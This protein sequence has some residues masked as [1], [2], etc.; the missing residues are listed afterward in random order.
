MILHE[1]ISYDVLRVIWW[2]L[3]G[4]L[5]VGFAVT[6]GFDLGVGALLRATAKTDVERRVVI[7]SIG[8][9]WEGNQVWLILGGGAIFAAWPQL[10]AVSFSGFYLAMFAVLVC[11][12]VRPLAFKFRSKRED[13]AWRNRW[14]WLLTLSGWGAALVFGVA[15]GNVLQGI[16]FHLSDDLRIHYEGTFFQLFSPFALLC[17]LVSLCMLLMHGATWLVF[18]TDGVV[19]DRAIRWGAVAAVLTVLLY[20]AAGLWLTKLQGYVLTEPMSTGGPSNPLIKSASVAGGAWLTNYA[21]APVLWIVPAVGLLMPL[22]AAW[23]MKGRRE[24][25]A[26]LCSGLGIAG[27]VLS[28]GVSMFPFIL[29]S[30]VDPSMSLMVWDASSSHLT[31]F[32]MLVSTIIFLPII[33]IYTS[34]VYSIMRGKVDPQAI[35]EGRGHSY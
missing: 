33:L 3:L 11:L 15:M 32:I 25:T 1:L 9:I 19:Q 6:D 28:V 8:P 22:I 2:L 16:P 18:K 29:P 17:G 5:L 7:N 23:A 26:L 4:I 21:K 30:S 10:Y 13:M 12:I 31:L 34:W 24:W 27:I 35:A 14:D 20:L